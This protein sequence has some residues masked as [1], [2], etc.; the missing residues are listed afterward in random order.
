MQSRLLLGDPKQG[1]SARDFRMPQECP[2]VF[3]FFSL[4][5][6]MVS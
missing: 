5:E 4:F 2:A 6:L 1:I 3:L